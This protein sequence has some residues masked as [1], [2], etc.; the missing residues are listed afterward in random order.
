M[1]EGE[2][3]VCTLCKEFLLLEDFPPDT[4]C[5]SD[6]RQARCRSCI[7]KWIKEHYR[8]NPADHMVRRAYA[9]AMRKG[10]EFN[11]TVDDITPLPETCPVFGFLL[12]HSNGQQ[13][14]YA[15]SLDRIDNRKG[16]VVGNVVVISYLANR[17]KNDGTAEQHERIA[18]WMRE[19]EQK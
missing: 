4:R 12:E 18:E 5:K 10:L 3:K 2:R 19:Q 11:V 8:R 14:P 6:G 17:L 9:R 16:Y 1:I 13:N 7:N 15:M